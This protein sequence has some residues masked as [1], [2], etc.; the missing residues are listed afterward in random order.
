MVVCEEEKGEGVSLDRRSNQKYWKFVVG[1]G[2]GFIVKK[3]IND[4]GLY[5]RV[6]GVGLQ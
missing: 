3:V 5:N 4:L 6:H 2:V 1:E